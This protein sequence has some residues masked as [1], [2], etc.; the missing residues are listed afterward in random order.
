MILGLEHYTASKKLRLATVSSMTLFASTIWKGNIV[1]FYYD[2][3]TNSIFNVFSRDLS[4]NDRIQLEKVVQDKLNT[5][6][7]V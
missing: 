4:Q 2:K 7:K 1:M 3:K 6:D 5:L